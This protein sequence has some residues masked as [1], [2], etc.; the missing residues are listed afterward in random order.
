MSHW[1]FIHSRNIFCEKSTNS[2]AQLTWIMNLNHVTDAEIKK[3]PLICHE[4]INMVRIL[5]RIIKL[6]LTSYKQIQIQ[7][8][9]LIE[10]FTENDKVTIRQ[11][12]SLALFNL[13]GYLYKNGLKWAR[14]G[15]HGA[16]HWAFSFRAPN[17]AQSPALLSNVAEP[18]LNMHKQFLYKCVAGIEYSVEY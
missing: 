1:L 14:I 2:E 4:G 12:T 15:I 8:A 17:Y 18:N 3:C 13:E 9:L 10:P 7:R 5:V 6:W 11:C 16:P